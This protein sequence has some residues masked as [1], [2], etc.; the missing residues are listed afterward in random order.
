MSL[1]CGIP[2]LF[3]SAL[4]LLPSASAFEPTKTTE[5]AGFERDVDEYGNFLER[6]TVLFKG[7]AVPTINWESTDIANFTRGLTGVN[8]TE[9]FEFAYVLQ[10]LSLFLNLKPAYNLEMCGKILKFARTYLFVTMA[11]TLGFLLVYRASIQ[12]YRYIRIC[13]TV[14]SSYTDASAYFFSLPRGKKISYIQ[15]HIMMAPLHKLRHNAPYIMN[16]PRFPNLHLHLGTL[17]SRFHFFLLFI[18]VFSNVLYCTIFIPWNLSDGPTGKLEQPTKAALVAEFRGRTGVMATVNMVPLFI[19]MMRNN[20]FG[21]TVEVGFDTWNLFHRWL[22]RIV[23]LEA[24]AHMCAWTVNEV[25]STGW[26]GVWHAYK[27]TP[28][29][30]VGLMAEIALICIVVLSVSPFRHAHYEIF[31]STHQLFVLF[32]VVGVWWHLY[33]DDLPQMTYANLAVATWILDRLMRIGWICMRNMKLDRKI[34]RYRVNVAEITALDDAVRLSVEMMNPWEFKPGQHAYIYIPRIGWHQSHPFSIAWSSTD[35][36]T[37]SMDF[38]FE[39]PPLPHDPELDPPRF[40]NSVHGSPARNRSSV[41]T[42]NSFDVPTPL[43]ESPRPSSVAMQPYPK[44]VVSHSENS[45]PRL[46]E[47]QYISSARASQIAIG[48]PQSRNN[49]HSTLVPIHHR[50]ILSTATAPKKAVMHFTIS[51][52]SGF[53]KRLYDAAA[54]VDL[55]KS[56][57]LR[58][59]TLIEGPYGG[60]HSYD[61]YGTVLL[62]GGGVGITHAIG[63][64]RHLIAGYS[65]GIVATHKIKLVWVVRTK[66]HID[67]AKD[68]LEEIFA[69]PNCRNVLTVDIY[70]TRPSK[71]G[72]MHDIFGAGRA[73]LVNMHVGRPDFDTIV[74]KVVAKRVGAIAVNVCGG[75][76]VSD[77]LRNATRKYVDVARVDYTEESFSW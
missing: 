40:P 37:P 39:K 41:A 16:I 50:D 33:L 19:C 6:R 3:L 26:A 75:G 65:E 77:G 49:R 32:F 14:S 23:F 54:A 12:H 10:S 1:C 61:S 38:D 67:W 30:Q 64:V 24:M 28:F 8:N 51:T 57:P 74:E 13:T 68:W 17:P 45:V 5:L 48:G 31:L 44:I 58:L 59:T 22:G 63:Y 11:V 25:D 34:G 20:W 27:I 55:E 69:M 4:L 56:G 60:Y 15:K 72:N 29:F 76:Q 18:Y 43:R 42:S 73:G 53:T 71:N 46:R 36:G 21:H 9:N 52:H 7:E 35:T 47:S 70:I 66:G 2:L 62:V